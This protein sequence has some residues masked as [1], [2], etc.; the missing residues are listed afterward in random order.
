MHPIIVVGPA[1]TAGVAEPA[2]HRGHVSEVIRAIIIG[3][4]LHLL[5]GL[6]DRRGLGAG[7]LLPRGRPLSVG[8]RAPHWR[9]RPATRPRSA[10]RLADGGGCRGRMMRHRDLFPQPE[11]EVQ[12]QSDLVAGLP[13][14]V[15][16]Q[17]LPGGDLL[18]RD[19]H[20]T[21]Q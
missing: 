15:D 2:V 8:G 3:N 9:R 18:W 10:A 6:T 16:L 1:F 17:V 11:P 14:S 4:S 21:A 13:L 19:G 7:Q 5:H 20:L 12:V